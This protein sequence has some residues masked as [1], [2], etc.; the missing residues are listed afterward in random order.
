MRYVAL[1]DAESVYLGCL[2]IAQWAVDPG[3]IQEAESPL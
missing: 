1:R 3:E 2:E